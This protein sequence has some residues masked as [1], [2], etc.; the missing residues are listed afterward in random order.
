MAARSLTVAEARAAGV[1]WKQLQSSRWSKVGPGRYA[2]ARTATDI[3]TILDSVQRRLPGCV[4]SGLTAAWLHGLDV[5]PCDPVEVILPHHLGV[6]ARKGVLVHRME[7]GDGEITSRRGFPATTALRTVIDLARR[8][9]LVEAVVLADMALHAELV[10]LPELQRYV[11][12]HVG[13]KGIVAM[14]RVLSLAEPKSESP[15]ESRLRLVIVSRGL[16]RPEAQT[17]I[18]DANG[19]LLGR[20]DLYYPQARLGIEYDGDHHH[21]RLADDDRRQNDL[22]LGDVRLLRYTKSDVYGD[23]DR[24]EM[25]V[26]F[27][28]GDWAPKRR[29]AARKMG[30]WA[31]KRRV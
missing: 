24:I 14:R 22:H 13:A 7:I 21:D 19:R 17:E 20:I 15:M 27:A 25:Q 12:A 8:P 26:R 23:P 18:R 4:F 11:D 6:S 2:I 31:P 9:P 1:S 29:A 3:A 16:L 5:P 30:D 10:R 28:L